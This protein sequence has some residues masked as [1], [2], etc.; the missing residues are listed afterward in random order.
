[1]DP[2]VIFPDG[3]ALVAGHI[4]AQLILRDNAA[5][6]VAS[7]VPNPR[8]DKFVLVRRLGGPR[9]NVAVDNPMLGIECW[10]LE[11]DGAISLAQLVR[12]IVLAMPGAIGTPAVAVYDVGE[13][14][15]PQLLPDPTSDHPRA[16]FTV[17]VALR[18]S[19]EVLIP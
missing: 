11:D 6:K 8:P 3:Q 15:G 7:R 10:D 12:G 18:G 14:S 4:R 1:M 17:S 5:V 16:V 2:V 13:V 19:K 9:L